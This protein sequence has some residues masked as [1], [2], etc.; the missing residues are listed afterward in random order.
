MIRHALLNHL[1]PKSSR[2]PMT[3]I[4]KMRKSLQSLLSN[5][6]NPNQPK[7][8]IIPQTMSDSYSEALIPLGSD[9]SFRFKYLH[10]NTDYV[11][12]G[13]LLED[14]DTFAVHISYKHNDPLQDNTNDSSPLGI[15]T[16]LVDDI[17]I[18]DKLKS[19]EDIKLTG[20]V[21]WTGSS[22]MEILMQV[23]QND[24]CAMDATFLMVARCPFD[25]KAAKV[26][27]LNA[28]N[29]NERRVFAQ[30]E[31]RKAT[32][33]QASKTNLLK[34][35]PTDEEAGEIHDLFVNSLNQ[36]VQAFSNRVLLDGQIWMESCKLK[37]AMTAMPEH[38]NIHGKL[39][40]GHIMRKG[41]ELAMANVQL[42]TR[43][44]SVFIES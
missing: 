25:N 32:R 38:R 8:E 31:L 43:V 1:Q 23:H 3:D 19:D 10:S 21:S 35:P 15:V 33:I 44:Q 16:A 11:R 29:S 26:C 30:A 9:E 2:R 41:F 18:H 42:V 20:S 22:S 4:I 24:I 34:L 7:P 40:G 14:L 27:P 5:P 6:Y 28:V 17:K 13:R 39:F 36:S 12:F 37:S